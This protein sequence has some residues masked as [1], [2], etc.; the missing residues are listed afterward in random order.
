M[1]ITAILQPVF[2]VALL[3]VVMTV[4]MFFTRI[5]AMARLR[6][7]PQKGQDTQQLKG[8][9][10]KEVTRISNNY[11]HLFE[12]PT[13]FYAVAISI[14]LLNYVDAIHVYC[15]WT[16]A[17]TRI[18]HSLVQATADIVLVRFGVFIVSWLVLSMMIIRATLTVFGF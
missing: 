16:Y 4:W 7:H 12:Q 15:A 1:E 11:N 13:L 9:L 17:I 14:A 3:T 6:I 2:V 18:V 8:L 5:P 10:P